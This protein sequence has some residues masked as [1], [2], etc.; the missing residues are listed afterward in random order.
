MPAMCPEPESTNRDLP[1]TSPGPA[2]VVF[3]DA[4]LYAML[5]ER[6]QNLDVLAT[7]SGVGAR[8]LERYGER[9][10]AVLRDA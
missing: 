8:K 5:R 4:T 2:Y 3:H 7:I 10:L 6:P 9:F 1:F